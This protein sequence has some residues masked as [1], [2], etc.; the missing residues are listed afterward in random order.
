MSNTALTLLLSLKVLFLPEN[1][2]FLQKNNDGKVMR[3]L[4]LKDVFSETKYVGV[5]V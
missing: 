2:D 3:A 4:A 1:A 5:F